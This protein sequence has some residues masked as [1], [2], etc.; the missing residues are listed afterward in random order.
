MRVFPCA[1]LAG[2]LV[3]SGAARGDDKDEARNIV[4]KA[5]QVRGG[6]NVKAAT[7]KGKGKISLGQDIE[8]NGEW[9][10]QLPKQS[11]SRINIDFNGNQMTRIDVLNGDKGWSAASGMV[12]ELNEDQL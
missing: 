2:C 1:W 7:W 9:W 3:L 11:K 10:A 4:Q 12:E 8:F 5:I 6:S